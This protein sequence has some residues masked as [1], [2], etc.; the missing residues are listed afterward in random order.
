VATEEAQYRPGTIFMASGRHGYVGLVRLESGGL[1]VAAA[2][3]VAEVRAAG[4][5]GA[6][7][8]RLLDAVGWPVPAG[9]A[10]SGWRGTAALTRRA[11][12]LSAPRLFV[13]GD[14]AGYVEPFTGE[15]MAWALASAA[16]V[17]PLAARAVERWQPDLGRAWAECH[18]RTVT[19]R[20]FTCRA[21]AAVL[22]RPWLTRI[23]VGLL[24]R[25]PALATPFVRAVNAPD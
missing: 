24:A 16:A 10:G 15:G 22:R 5:P 6:L 19:R 20:Q 25:L 11:T 17:A 13:L 4:S 21:M 9:L 23:V 7:A 8:A 3:D 2:L 18:R 12:S 1:G 14:A